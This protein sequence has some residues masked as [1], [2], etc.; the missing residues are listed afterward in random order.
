M[1][2]V[3]MYLNENENLQSSG[4]NTIF[5]IFLGYLIAT[6]RILQHA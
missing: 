2:I 3:W 1:L 6:D 5:A 4:Q